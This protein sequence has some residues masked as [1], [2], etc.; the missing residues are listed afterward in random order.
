MIDPSSV[1]AIFA[2]MTAQYVDSQCSN[3]YKSQ[4]SFQKLRSNLLS[5]R[6]FERCYILARWIRHIFKDIIERPQRA[7]SRRHE[8]HEANHGPRDSSVPSDNTGWT[9]ATTDRPSDGSE[10]IISHGS[11]GPPSANRTLFSSPSDISRT[12]QNVDMGN[13]A[14]VPNGPYAGNDPWNLTALEDSPPQSGEFPSMNSL[15]CQ[16]LQFQMKLG[17]SGFGGGFG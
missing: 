7:P 1:T 6:Q 3:T 11:Y 14:L 17:F 16:G 2:A 9:V 4:L 8:A 10:P 13:Q 5:L 12:T 15:Q